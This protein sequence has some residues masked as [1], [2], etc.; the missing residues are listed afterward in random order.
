MSPERDPV[1]E[2]KLA[3]CSNVHAAETLAGIEAELDRVAVKVR[4]QVARR[5]RLGVGLWLPNAVVDEL[6]E[7]PAR[8]A[9]FAA[10]L[11]ERRIE[12]F[13]LNAFPFGGFHQKRV[14]EAV[15]QPSWAEP[16]R[17]AYTRR[18]AE[19][20]A[21][22]LPEG[23]SGSISTCPVGL[24]S[25]GFDRVAAVE[26]L[27]ACGRSLAE[28]EQRT[29]REIVL[30]LE[31]EPGAILET[32]G[33]AIAFLDSEV[34]VELDEPLRRHLG[35][36]L[37]ACHE[38][39]MFEDGAAAIDRL[40]EARIRLAKLQLSSAIEIREP[41]RSKAALERLRGFDEG[42]YFHQLA[43]LRSDGSRAVFQDL[44]EFFQ[45]VEKHEELDGVERLRVHFHVPIFAAIDGDLTTTRD[46]LARIVRRARETEATRHFE[47]ETYTFDVIPPE[48]RAALGADDLVNLL[49][50]EWRQ[51]K[52]WL[53]DAK[54]SRRRAAPSGSADEVE[55]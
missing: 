55:P 7:D 3:Y 9:S 1:H 33:D 11:A 36:C 47:I 10:F 15:F 53:G 4:G 8:L 32:V 46:D 2:P 17:L 42:R 13:T 49:A 23:A 38:A 28:L 54:R 43:Y 51:A 22:L 16:K 40:L 29:G 30:G 31:P 24:P 5:G 37:D 35:V 25:V 14:K 6:L 45:L 18:C 48:E 44:A 52:E 27:R 26:N 19:V 12:V 34:F 39:V 41:L 20:L 50:R 21:R